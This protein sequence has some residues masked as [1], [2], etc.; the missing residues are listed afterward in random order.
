MQFSS[1]FSCSL[2]PRVKYSPQH[3][4]L[5][6][7]Q[8]NALPLGSEGKFR[9]HTKQQVTLLLFRIPEFGSS[10]FQ[11]E[12]GKAMVTWQCLKCR[13]H[14]RDRNMDKIFGKKTWKPRRRWADIIKIILKEV[15]RVFVDW[16]QVV[17]RIGT[18][19]GNFWRL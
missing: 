16:I 18:S 4:V 10:V 7:C 15:W 8:A 17:L 14:G 3:P 13:A 11:T 5:N 19:G 9:S 6:L 1:S 12:A 2:C